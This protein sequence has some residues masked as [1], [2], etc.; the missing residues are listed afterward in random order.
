MGVLKSI[1]YTR[2]RATVK[3][4]FF[5]FFFF[6][7]WT[8]STRRQPEEYKSCNKFP[9]CMNVCECS[10]VYACM[11]CR[12]CV[13]ACC[14]AISIYKLYIIGCRR[15]VK[16]VNVNV[17]AALPSVGSV[18]SRDMTHAITG[19]RGALYQLLAI[20]TTRGGPRREIQPPHIH[21]AP[22]NIN[23]IRHTERDCSSLVCLHL[24]FWHSF[25]RVIARY[26]VQMDGGVRFHR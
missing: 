25:V 18:V 20:A 14:I 24:I 4:F 17:N 8:D 26:I 15:I 6:L 23:T 21:T 3:E 16:N 19:R 5:F 22:N 10:C 2:N 7:L 13:R 12:A 9:T 11:T 1:C